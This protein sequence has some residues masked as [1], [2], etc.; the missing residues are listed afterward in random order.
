M[1]RVNVS[2]LIRRAVDVNDDVNM[3]RERFFRSIDITYQ[4]G[5]ELMNEICEQEN[6]MDDYPDIAKDF[7]EAA[8]SLKVKW[9]MSRYALSHYGYQV[10]WHLWNK[11]R[12]PQL[13]A[14][15]GKYYDAIIDPSKFDWEHEILTVN[16]D[17]LVMYDRHTKIT[18]RFTL[19]EEGLLEIK[20]FPQHRQHRVFRFRKCDAAEIFE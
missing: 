6:A 13:K 5:M 3:E 8:D 20:E 11:L 10:K 17:R 1:A 7:E 2:S 19:N 16:D 4:K 15:L 14:I 18:A 9:D 12:L